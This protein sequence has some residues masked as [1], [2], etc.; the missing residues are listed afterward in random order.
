MVAKKKL[1]KKPA[2]K[3]AA[4]T[5][6][7]V[8]AK[9]VKKTKPAK[10]APSKNKKNPA[11]P[12]AGKF[13]IVAE[14]MCLEFDSEISQGFTWG[15]ASSKT[16][17]IPSKQEALKL[18]DEYSMTANSSDPILK[19][20]A[21]SA[22]KH[23]VVVHD[24]SPE[25]MKIQH[26]VFSKAD[27]KPRSASQAVS[28]ARKFFIGEQKKNQ[29]RLKQEET[30][31]ANRKKILA[32]ELETEI[33]HEQHVNKIALADLNEEFKVIT[34]NLRQESKAVSS[35]LKKFTKKWG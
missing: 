26:F 12:L 23:L 6:P 15:D 21:V 3:K 1:A 10:V 18:I 22:K 4:K 5:P 34:T 30:A 7:K 28:L 31:L 29:E 32:K 11:D 13:I 17:L 19:A 9:K 8:V 25:T 24:V 27:K 14:N 20:K 16:A 33:K 2:K 35:Q